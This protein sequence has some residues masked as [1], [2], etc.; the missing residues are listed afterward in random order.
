MAETYLP[1]QVLFPLSHLMNIKKF[2]MKTK[3]I[4][5]FTFLFVLSVQQNTV[6]AQFLKKLKNKVEKKLDEVLET[7]D[8]N[9]E[10]NDEVSDSSDNGYD[11]SQYEAD[12]GDFVAGN[13][14]IFKDT[15]ANN[16]VTGKTPS[17]WTI[18]N[19]R[20]NDN[21][22]IVAVDGEKMIRLAK[23][24]GI[25]P[26][27]PGKEKDYIPE[28]CTLEFDASFSANALDQRYYIVFFD[29]E[30]QN[31]FVDWDV[32]DA[33][34]TLATFGVTDNLTEGALEGHKCFEE[35]PAPV[36]RHIA[37]K[38]QNNSFEIYYDGQ[39]VFHKGDLKGNMIGLTISR[40]EFGTNDRYIKNVVIAT[41]Q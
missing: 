27:M 3:L 14:V 6:Q 10:N 31:D 13:T 11:S 35:S 39:H 4:F 40:S 29:L 25:S 15:P 16:E 17:K 34:L 33:E 32:R 41:N 18:F 37:I 28:N 36:W 38:Y 22:E 7:D 9:S 20:K 23:G 2:T 24:Q 5:A 19:T 21:T 30:N 26:L 8:Q 12:Y 1:L